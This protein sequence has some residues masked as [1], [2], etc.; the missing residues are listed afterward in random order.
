L[1]HAKAG[2]AARPVFKFLQ[3]LGDADAEPPASL[4]DKEIAALAGT[5]EFGLGV[6]LG[7]LAF[8][9]AGAHSASIGFVEDKGSVVM[10]VSDP[11]LVLTTRRRQEPK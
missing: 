4:S 1:A 7:D 8:Y 3:L 11:E 2:E 10:T 9:P 5:Y 6:H